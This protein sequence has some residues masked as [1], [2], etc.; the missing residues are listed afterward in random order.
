MKKAAIL[1][2]NLVSIFS[3]YIV[4]QRISVRDRFIMIITRIVFIPIANRTISKM[5]TSILAYHKFNAL[6]LIK[7]GKNIISRIS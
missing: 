1:S 5:S 3:Q 2:N 4:S 6:K 7:K